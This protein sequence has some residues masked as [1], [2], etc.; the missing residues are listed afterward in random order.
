[1]AHWQCAQLAVQR[2]ALALVALSGRRIN[3][4]WPGNVFQLG[5]VF[6]LGPGSQCDFVFKSA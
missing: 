3:E 4:P 5:G 2:T 1:M 6:V